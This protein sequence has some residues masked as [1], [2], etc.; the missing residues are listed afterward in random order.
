[1]A[2][3]R[4]G[5]EKKNRRTDMTTDNLTLTPGGDRAAAARPIWRQTKRHVR[6]ET[7]KPL[8]SG[9]RA[10]RNGR[11]KKSPGRGMRNKKKLFP[12][13][14]QHWEQRYGKGGTLGEGSGVLAESRRC[15]PKSATGS[16]GA[17]ICPSCAWTCGQGVRFRESLPASKG[18]ESS[19][20][21]PA[22][23]SAA[24]GQL[25]WYYAQGKS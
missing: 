2:P 13:S 23:L 20:N 24:D 16:A 15:A 25:R 3:C 17:A 6:V 22:E 5:Y 19:E 18:S 1:V 7:F 8:V 21:Q 14:H 4:R 10:L 12:G 11:D 9:L